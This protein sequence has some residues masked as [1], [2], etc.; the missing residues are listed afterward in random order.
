M[1]EISILHLN[2]FQGKFL[3]E[4]IKFVKTHD[5]DILH[6][7]EV[8]GGK[9]S[10]GGEYTYPDPEHQKQAEKNASSNPRYA[11]LN[12]F[13]EIKKRLNYDGICASRVLLKG[14][15][16]SFNGNGTFYKKSLNLKEHKI[17]WL[18][19]IFETDDPDDVNWRAAGYNAITA[20]FEIGNKT[21][22]S[23]N[24]HLV[25][26]PTPIDEPYKLEINMPLVDHMRT[27]PHPW[28]LTGDF[29]VDKR[30][31]VVQELNKIGINLS[32]KNG[33]TNTINERIH[34]AKELFPPGLAVDFAYT[35]EDVTVKSCEI[36]N[37]ID[38]SDH[39]A[40]LT[41]IEI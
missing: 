8:S 29:N 27:L 11:G 18:H 20:E 12:I 1:A 24:T 7:Q 6:F 30:S 26:G 3:D 21:L 41:K 28:I 36:I 2:I 35:S 22:W 34:P 32:E 38:L 15:H 23:V 4:I 17:I 14:D 31:Q 37:K 19:E 40:I 5:V 16:N 9:F 39:Y 10:G 13:E 33:F 25:W